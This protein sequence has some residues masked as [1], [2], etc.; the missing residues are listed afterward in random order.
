MKVWHIKQK[1]QIANNII[2]NYIH[3]SRFYKENGAYSE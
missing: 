1:D 3:K 2:D